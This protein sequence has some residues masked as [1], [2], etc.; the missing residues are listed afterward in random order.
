MKDEFNTNGSMSQS[1]NSI[2]SEQ[3]VITVDVA[4]YEKF[5]REA[6]MSPEQK[7]EFLRSIWT[8]VTTFVAHGF[9]I[10]PLQQVGAEEPCG[11]DALGVD[12]PPNAALDDVNSRTEPEHTPKSRH[13]PTGR[14]EAE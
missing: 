10:H 7:E 1:R 2:S 14:L 3:R 4:L 8:V 13:G 5:I 11:K 9:G 6:E 12:Q